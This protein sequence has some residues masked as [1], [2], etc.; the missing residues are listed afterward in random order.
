MADCALPIFCRIGNLHGVKEQLRGSA[1]TA[2]PWCLAI[3]EHVAASFLIPCA[4][5]IDLEKT[6]RQTVHRAT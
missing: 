2:T 4:I 5:E 3:L 1:D 6:F